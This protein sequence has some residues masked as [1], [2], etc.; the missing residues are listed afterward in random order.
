MTPYDKTTFGPCALCLEPTE[1]VKSHIIPKFNFRKLKPGGRSYHMLSLDSVIPT[2]KG[3]S[4]L[5]ERLLCKNC[6][7]VIL[8]DGEAYLSNLLFGENGLNKIEGEGAW[9]LTR[10]DYGRIQKCLLSILWRMSLSTHEFF[11]FI[12]LGE[13]DSTKLRISILNSNPLPE[14]EY[15]LTCVVPL[16]EGKFHSDWMLTPHFIEVDGNQIYHCLIAGYFFSFVV[17]TAPIS[18]AIRQI[19]LKENG[20]WSI[21]RSEVR[22]MPMLYELFSN[23]T[24]AERQR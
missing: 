24:E 12:Q 11:R 15:P 7:N 16:I 9:M 14:L 10:L 5:R 13:H 2:R 20:A 19:V 18:P 6:D 3:Q 23:V 17:G 1:L 8:R 22:N 4:E 21:L